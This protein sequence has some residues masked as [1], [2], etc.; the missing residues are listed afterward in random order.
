MLKEMIVNSVIQH[1]ED[2][3]ENYFIT[4]DT[5]VDYSGYSR[6]YLQITF[7]DY[8]GIPIGKYIRVRRASRAA[9]LLRLT[10]LSII[11]ISERLFY[12]SQQTFTREFKKI[13]GYTPRQYRC[14]SFWSFENLLG[15]RDVN[16]IY[17]TPTLCYLNRKEV[18]GKTFDHKEL[19]LY[20]GVDART[21]WGRAYSH[22]IDNDTITVSNMIPFNS[23]DNI[24]ARTVIWTEKE[25]SD[26]SIIIDEGLYAHFQF[27]ASM[28]QYIHC[29]YNIYYNSLPI[30][31]LNKRDAYDIEIISKNEN[32]TLNCQYYLPVFDEC[33]IHVNK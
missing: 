10:K 15:R 3:L 13:M 8:M 18:F 14:N 19:I 30:Y 21:R 33:A 23:N 22:F 11:D 24:I 2:N 25:S 6:R 31:N 7:K 17:P 28:D 4:I 12:D 1:I 26:C 32:G 16:R 27:T 9:A 29:L 5:L 20:T